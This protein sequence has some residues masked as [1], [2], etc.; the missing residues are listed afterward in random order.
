MR[1]WRIVAMTMVALAGAISCGEDPPVS[2]DAS[3]R[4]QIL[5][6]AAAERVKIFHEQITRVDVVEVVGRGVD[7]FVR[8]EEI[9]PLTDADRRHRPG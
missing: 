2:L 7:G 3:D 1:P 5:A 4:A 9:T 8:L 6:A